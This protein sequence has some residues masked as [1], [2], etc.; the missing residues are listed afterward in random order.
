M[1]VH[2]DHGLVRAGI[3]AH[4]KMSK[5]INLIKKGVDNNHQHPLLSLVAH[6]AGGWIFFNLKK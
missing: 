4:I 2:P 5:R 3:A 1:I 6:S